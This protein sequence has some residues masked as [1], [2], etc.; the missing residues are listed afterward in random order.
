MTIGK[1]YC[2]VLGGGGFLRA[3]Y[4]CNRRM[5]DSV[6]AMLDADDEEGSSSQ[7]GQSQLVHFGNPTGEGAAA[8][9]IE[10]DADPEDADYPDSPP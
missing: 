10:E 9:G 6:D 3:R 2:R 8:P 5:R 7:L 1:C 4:P